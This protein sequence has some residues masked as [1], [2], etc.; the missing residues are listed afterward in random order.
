MNCDAPS[1]FW[2]CLT[3]GDE[4]PF[5]SNVDPK[6]YY[7]ALGLVGL[8]AAFVLT[9]LVDW[10]FY[11]SLDHFQQQMDGYINLVRKKVEGVQIDQKKLTSIREK[12]VKQLSRS[13][14]C[15]RLVNTLR[16][17]LV[18]PDPNKFN[19][20]IKDFQ[21]IEDGH[22]K[23]WNNDNIYSEFDTI[24]LIGNVLDPEITT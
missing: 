22:V 7:Y 5:F 9:I 12:A 15:S 11:R 17:E 24:G 1:Y 8:Y 18:R 3:L 20:M 4:C 13:Q 16:R 19:V 14:E 21:N 10:R 6:L 23:H 2:S